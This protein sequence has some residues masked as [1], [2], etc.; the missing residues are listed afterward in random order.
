MTKLMRL[1]YAIFDL[2]MTLIDSIGPLMTSAN[3]LAGEFGL[4]EVTREAVLAAEQSAPNVTFESLWRALWGR[5]D[6]AWYEVY[7]DRLA[8][9][10]YAAMA[11]YPGS[12][13]TLEALQARGIGL[14]LASNRDR[15]RRAL[16]ALGLEP[17]F[18]A[19]VG[20]LDVVRPKPAPDML[21]RALDLLGAKPEEAV[22]IGDSKGDII[23]ATS[24]GVR[25]FAVTTGGHD[26]AGLTAS[27]A[28]R[29]GDSL[30]ELLEFFPG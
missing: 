15:P 18:Q 20:Q 16:A 26:R 12:R 6:P 4:P 23:C 24:A 29:V 21:L 2:D 5:Y 28:W 13:E 27:G 11:L 22:Y 19:V 14:A 25:S 3:L 1:R 10:E 30:T 17:V 9:R 8:D 7:R